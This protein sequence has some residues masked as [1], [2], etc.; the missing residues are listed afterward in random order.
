LPAD[1]S[2]HKNKPTITDPSLAPPG[3]SVLYL[4]APMPNLQ[5]NMDLDAA[6][7]SV[8]EKFL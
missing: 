1:P 5:G 7:L 4:L 3:H 8:R 2:F 6:A